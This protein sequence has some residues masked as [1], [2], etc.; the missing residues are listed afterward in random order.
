MAG[1]PGIIIFV[2]LAPSDADD[3][4]VAAAGALRPRAAA[5]SWAAMAAGPSLPSSSHAWTGG[6]GGGTGGWTGGGRGGGPDARLLAGV[7]A[8]AGAGATNAAGEANAAGGAGG[9][10]TRRVGAERG[11]MPPADDRRSRLMPAGAGLSLWRDET[12]EV[13]LLGWVRSWDVDQ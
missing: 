8:F 12:L 9:A 2:G 7:G 1:E 5:A 10:D 13:P 11:G 4:R 3:A 6:G